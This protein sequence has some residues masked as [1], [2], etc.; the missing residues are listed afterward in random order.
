[1]ER[2]VLHGILLDQMV[3]KGRALEGIYLKDREHFYINSP[4]EVGVSSS[5]FFWA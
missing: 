3:L 5:I 2:T 1:M 4:F